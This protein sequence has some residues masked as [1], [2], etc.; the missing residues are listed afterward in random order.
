MRFSITVFV[1]VV[2][3]L[4]T[5]FD[6]SA[7]TASNKEQSA[8]EKREAAYR[9]NNLGAA[10]LEQFKAKEAIESFTRALGIKPD[11]TIARINLSIALYYLPDI[12]AAKHEAEKALVQDSSA[13]QP[14]YILG[15][16]GR[17]Q[18][19]F[20]DAIAEFEKVAKADAEDVGTKVNLGQIFLQQKK[21]PEAIV[22]FR[23]AFEAEPYN[24]TALYNLGLL[25]TRTG[26]KTEGQQSQSRP[27]V[28]RRG[29]VVRSV[30]N[31][32]YGV[33]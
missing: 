30:Q 17:A 22:A 29:S 21:Y 19:R 32:P 1:I 15:L 6:N 5:L 25:L 14:H 26:K 8:F 20:E 23:K 2:L 3:S 31:E 7:R 28:Q 18:N 9:A 13:P 16:I 33:C 27:D 24:E 4:L 12:D 10:Y 11:L